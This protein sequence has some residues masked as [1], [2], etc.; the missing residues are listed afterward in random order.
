M[1]RNQLRKRTKRLPNGWY[2]YSSLGVPAILERMRKAVE[3]AGLPLNDPAD[4][5]FH[6]GD[7]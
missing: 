7:D 1:G 5:L 3:V 4:L 2:V 6:D